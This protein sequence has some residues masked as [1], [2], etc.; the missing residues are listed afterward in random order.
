MEPAKCH[1]LRVARCAPLAKLRLMPESIL[2]QIWERF[3]NLF[4]EDCDLLSFEHCQIG[5]W[6][7]SGAWCLGFGISSLPLVRAEASE[8][9]TCHH[10]FA[11]R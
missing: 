2:A 1:L 10:A 6:N 5:I 4:R 3:T 9:K 8:W 11:F 7:L